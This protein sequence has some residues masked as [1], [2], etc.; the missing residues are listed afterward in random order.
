MLERAHQFALS[1]RQR[2]SRLA[3]EGR[4]F[5][6]MLGDARRLLLVRAW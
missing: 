4:R 1:V 6:E 2:G 5:H 3:W